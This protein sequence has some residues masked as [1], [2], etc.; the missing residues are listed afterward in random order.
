MAPD[1]PEGE[2]RPMRQPLAATTEEFQTFG[3][4]HL[5]LLV[6][7]VLGCVAVAFL[8]RR[9]RAR[10]VEPSSPGRRTWPADQVRVHR[11]AA[12]AVLAVAVPRLLWELSP[13]EINPRTSYP[14]HLSDLS[15]MVAAFALWTGRRRAAQL[16]YYW[17][18]VLVPQAML[19][20]DL[21]NTFPN[22]RYLLFWA[23]HLLVVWVAVYLTWSG[24]ARPT[25][26]G[27]RF[28]LLVTLVWLVATM[29]FNA[30]METNYGYLNAK[31]PRGS[32]LDFFPEWPWYVGV[33][34]LLVAA[35]WALMTW[36][37]Q[38]RRIRRA[39]DRGGTLVGS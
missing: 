4:D 19:T 34:I 36:P 23:I 35:V 17:G 38:R 28:T 21:V 11:W 31:P 24:R 10:G 15:W 22:P 29:T 3:P 6:L 32:I 26:S 39:A 13:G 18:L 12:V 27:Y 37:W 14:I 16:L 2:A 1:V 8:G 33:Q 5:G 7:T 30:V 20:P 25:W 9:L